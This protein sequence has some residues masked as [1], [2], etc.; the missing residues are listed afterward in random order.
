MRYQK[1]AAIAVEKNDPQ[2][3]K[4]FV[5]FSFPQSTGH[6]KKTRLNSA[7][8]ASWAALM[9][10]SR[11]ISELKTPQS[12]GFTVQKCFYDVRTRVVPARRQR[13]KRNR[14]SKR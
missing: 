12:P 1:S 3:L 11:L 2:P 13:R 9:T 8:L 7:A 5:R 14:F 4:G 10:A 6:Q